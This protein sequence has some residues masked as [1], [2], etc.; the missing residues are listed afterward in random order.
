MKADLRTLLRDIQAAARIGHPES[1]WAALE[2]VLE[3]PQISGNHHLD[4]SFLRQVVLP[5]GQALAHPLLKQA[6]LRPLVTHPLA[7]MRAIAGAALV[8]RYLKGMNGTGLKDMGQ[9]AQ[10]PRQDVRQAVLLACALPG[11]SA[12]DKQTEIF[13]AWLVQPSPRLQGLALQ[14]LPYLPEQTVLAQLPKLEDYSPPQEPGVRRSLAEAVSKLGQGEYGPQVLA[15]LSTWAENPER[16]YWVITR[17]LSRSWAA[18]YPDQSLAILTHLAEIKGGRKKILN[19]LKALQ[20]HGAKTE[21]QNNLQQ[22]RTSGNPQLQSAA[23]KAEEK[24]VYKKEA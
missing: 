22:W 17:S 9:L 6:A 23:R 18:S 7:G 10:D 8:E 3:F 11:F 19:A 14:L 4:D 5:V 12:P 24:G 21:V 16:Y 20:S 13:E 1:V 2:E 15:I